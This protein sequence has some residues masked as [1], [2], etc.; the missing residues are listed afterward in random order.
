[1]AG[2]QKWTITGTSES[3]GLTEQGTPSKGVTVSFKL[4][5]GT[6]GTVF[7]PDPAFT[8]TNVT[9]LV[10]AR[11]AALASLKGLTGTLQGM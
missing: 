1:M 3:T 6:A 2:P 4:D 10:A 9:A 7:V 11:A 8:P 5:D